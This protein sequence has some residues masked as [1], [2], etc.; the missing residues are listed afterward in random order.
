MEKTKNKNNGINFSCVKCNEEFN[1]EVGEIDFDQNPPEFE[2]KLICP[3]CGTK[4]L[5]GKESVA[6]FELTEEGQVQLTALMFESTEELVGE[7]IMH[8]YLPMGEDDA[9]LCAEC[10]EA[11]FESFVEMLESEKPSRNA[12]CSCGSGKKYKKCC[13]KQEC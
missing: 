2:Y 4:A 9:C 8:C 10:M 6:K 5:T 13:M 7:S 11:G 1:F 12:P 3:Q